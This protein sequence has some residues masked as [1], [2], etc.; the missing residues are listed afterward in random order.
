MTIALQKFSKAQIK[1]NMMNKVDSN[2]FL[3]IYQSGYLTIKS[4]DERFNSYQ[5]GFPNKEIEEGILN[6]Q[7]PYECKSGEVDS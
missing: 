2:P 5:L 7:P 1:A 4:Y 6:I 3:V